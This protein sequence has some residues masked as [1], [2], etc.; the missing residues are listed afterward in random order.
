[1]SV[2]RIVQTLSL[3]A[4]AAAL[5]Q[6]GSVTTQSAEAVPAVRAEAAFTRF[7][8]G[9]TRRI[10]FQADDDAFAGLT[11]LEKQ[12]QLRDW[13]LFA[14]VSDAGLGPKEVREVLFELPPI[15]RGYLEPVASY[16]Y[17]ETRSRCIG[18]GQVI[19]LVRKGTPEEEAEQ[20]A[21][22]ADEQRKNLGEIPKSFVVFEYELRPDETLGYVTRRSLI[23]GNALFTE[24]AGYRQRSITSSVDLAAFLTEVDDLTF[25]SLEG[26]GLTLGGRRLAQRSRGLRAEDIAALWKS[27]V[28]V[29]P[30][31][32]AA[33]EFKARWKRRTY[34]TETEKALLESEYEQELKKL[35]ASGG[36]VEGS[37]FSLDPKFDYEK[38]AALFRKMIPFLA[39]MRTETGEDASIP[40]DEI[41]QTAAALAEHDEEPF[42]KIL[43]KVSRSRNLSPAAVG[44]MLDVA[45]F[46]AAR[47]DGDLK[48]TEVGMVLF[49][50]DLLAKLWALDYIDSAPRQENVEDFVSMLKVY[51]SP[52][53]LREME[54]LSGTRLWFGH[55]DKGFQVIDSGPCLLFARN[56]TRIYAASSNPLKPG[57]E[58]EPNAESAAFLGWWNNHYEEVA[59]F[60]P[61]YQRLNE[62]MKWSLLVSWLADHD[63][64]ERL[65]F[66]S[67]QE[68]DHANWF[69][70]W[71]EKQPDLQF[72]RWDRVGFLNRDP[73]T[74]YKGVQ[75]E[76]ISILYSEGFAK[77][78]GVTIL[79]GG[80]S[81]G[82]EEVFKAR[83]PLKEEI[84]SLLRR[85]HLDYQEIE[86]VGEGT[87]R[88]K[89]LEKAEFEFGEILGEN[90]R[91]VAQ[92]KPTAKLRTA[93]LELR[94]VPFEVDYRSTP[95]EL[96][97]DARAGGTEVGRLSVGTT[98]NGFTVG[99]KSLDLEQAGGLTHRVIDGILEG[100]EPL[101]VL[102]SDPRVAA[103][104]R[105][106][107]GEGY[108]VQMKGANHWL[109]L[110]PEEQPSATIVEGVQMRVGGWKDGAQEAP[111]WTAAWVEDGEFPVQLGDGGYLAVE[112][113]ASGGGGVAIEVR[114]NGPPP[115]SGGVEF[116]FGD[117]RVYARRDPASKG[118]YYFERKSLPEALQKDPSRLRE[119]FDPAAGPADIDSA[120]A[121][122]QQGAYERVGRDLSLDPILFKQRL[123]QYRADG[124][125]EADRLMATGR[126]AEATQILDT[127]SETFGNASDLSLRRAMSQLGERRTAVAVDALEEARPALRDPRPAIARIDARL[128][129]G[130]V[131]TAEEVGLYRIGRGLEMQE[132][133][134]RNPSLRMDTRFV[135]DLDGQLDFHALLLDAVRGR[136]VPVQDI[137]SPHIY[138]DV[139]DPGLHNLD[140]S[141]SVPPALP[142]AVSQR[143]VLTEL[144]SWEIAHAKPGVL[145]EVATKHQY[146][147]A[148][149]VQPLERLTRYPSLRNE[150][151]GSAT[152]RQQRLDC[153]PYVYLVT[154]RPVAAI[155]ISAG[156]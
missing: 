110:A 89:T 29:R 81:L 111:R 46:Q 124:I 152:D 21:H 136:K 80:V 117:A 100:R 30:I 97:I 121:H 25:V 156:R 31:R 122:L 32:Q 43:D 144:P 45:S 70:E 103:V 119:L 44:R 49:Y 138:L 77:A 84:P 22:I 12:Q 130:S 67:D 52:I 86:D 115:N 108:L 149:K 69:P 16:D 62:I 105:T 93:D 55:Q 78:G 48:G 8:E 13:L 98:K 7:P 34:S 40:T 14:V 71:V 65:G 51:V 75:T 36:L 10:D 126:H 128:A 150:P 137:R 140:W 133:A 109:R 23:D 18:N 96:R 129:Q 20:L 116:S 54:D 141:S 42:L 28:F 104:L 139:D 95:A 4:I 135:I 94:N 17:G 3:V 83:V 63:K 92:A 33:E 114:N 66:L 37:G 5:Y 76:A 132:Q 68:V 72:Q 24:K 41:Q 15:R 91:L 6:I 106:P 148:S 99:F 58:A 47:Y 56:A 112:P 154:T 9:V 102:A 60:E 85:S 79:S 64:M 127:L 153:D 87:F 57:E 53:Y 101:G 113:P 120:I 107:S 2:K 39:A 50:T 143:L 82:S 142:E 35:K 26:S 61:Q 88:L 73:R 118:R 134:L 151:C 38:L 123:Q 74:S 146:R 27:E 59:R 147:L 90:A 145:E 155:G 125:R 131:P 11:A 1:M 19:A